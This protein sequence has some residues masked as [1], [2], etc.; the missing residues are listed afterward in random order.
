MAHANIDERRAAV[1]VM[2]DGGLYS[3]RRSKELATEY[4]CTYGAIRNDIVFI[5]R[6]NDLPI[7]PSKN[8]KIKILVRDGY[9]CR[10]CGATDRYMV[11]DHVIPFYQGGTGTEDN[12]VAACASCNS[13]K[14][15]QIWTPGAIVE[16]RTSKETC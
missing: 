11:V 3:I 1:R 13:K 15:G 4:G 14:R 6:K 10:Y 5:Y 9:A 7:F 8:L 2:V 12:L 16:S